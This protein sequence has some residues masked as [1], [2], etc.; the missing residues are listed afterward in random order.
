[1]PAPAVLALAPRWRVPTLLL[2][3]GSDRC[4][5]PA[6]SAAFAAAAPRLV[7]TTREFRRSSTRSSTSPSRTRSWRV[8]TTWL[9]TLDVSLTEEPA[10][11]ARDPLQPIQTDEAEALGRFADRVWDD[12]IVP[13]ITKY[14]EVPAKSPMFDAD[15]KEHGYIDRVVRDAAAWVERQQ[16]QG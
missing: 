12:E 16:V 3:A 11:N 9:D 10:M 14:I 5:V 15:W 6:G 2:Y 7:V 8:L 1:M 4:V 13:Q